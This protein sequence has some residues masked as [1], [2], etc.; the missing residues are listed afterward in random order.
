MSTSSATTIGAF[1]A[2]MA[3][4]LQG[5]T[6]LENYRCFVVDKLRLQES[7]IPNL[8]IEPVSMTVMGDETGL[9]IF[10]MEYKVHAVVKVE[11]D[12]ADKQTQR[13]TKA[14]GQKGAFQMA[15]DAAAALNKYEVTGSENQVFM[16]ID[17][18]G[19]DDT[20]GLAY[21]TATFR[22]FVRVM[23]DG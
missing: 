17:N 23:T 2:A 8:Q 21:A 12:F 22:T 11:Y 9:N 18:G 14:T 5:Q 20:M 19:V 10:V 4:R 7:S 16:R 13:L 1:F 3:A 15:Y 6:G